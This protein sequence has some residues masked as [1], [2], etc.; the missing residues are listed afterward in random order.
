MGGYRP[1]ISDEDF[2]KCG[3]EA[4]KEIT[5]AGKEKTGKGGGGHGGMVG[6]GGKRQRMR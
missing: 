2:N 1:S 6:E 5:E 4:A 3:E